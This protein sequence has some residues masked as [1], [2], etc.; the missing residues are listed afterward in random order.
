[1]GQGSL[2]PSRVHVAG[3]DVLV[4]RPARRGIYYSCTTAP[5][6]QLTP[7]FLFF[8]ALVGMPALFVLLVAGHITTTMLLE[9][10]ESM[11]L[12]GER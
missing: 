11:E 9:L 6:C 1:M 3:A 10:R 5:F 4:G 8:Q 7:S 2:A 12:G